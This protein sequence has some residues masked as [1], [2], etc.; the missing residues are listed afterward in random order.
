MQD[1]RA[2]QP[3]GAGLQ[4]IGLREIEDAVV[5]LVPVLE[6]LADLR[7]GGAGF[8]AEEGVGEVVADV[9]V[10]RREVV[11]LGLAFLADQLGLLGA[12]VHVVRDRPH[13]VEELR[14]HRPAAVLLPD[15]LA[16]DA[17]RRSPRRPA[18]RVKRSLA[19]HAV[20]QALVRHAAFVGGL[21]GGGE[22][23]L[24]NAA[25]VGAVGVDVVRVQLDAQA[26]LEERA[27]HPGGRQAQQAAG[28]LQGG[29]DEGLD[30]L[31]DGFERSDCV[32]GYWKVKWLNEL[33]GYMSQPAFIRCWDERWQIRWRLASV[34]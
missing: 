1:A 30:V 21:G 18:R 16:D 9:V 13:V 25:A 19:D 14:V 34:R 15:R 12:L 3:A 27:R 33:L 6:A 10:L 4:A 26:G 29:F 7:L 11:A 28:V 8:E 20:A 31:G 2:D 5:A 22:P 17:S 32:H 23:A 24:V